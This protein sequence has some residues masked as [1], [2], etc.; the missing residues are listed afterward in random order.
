MMT[1]TGLGFRGHQSEADI[2]FRRIRS[3]D[4]IRRLYMW[5]TPGGGKTVIAFLAAKHLLPSIAD[6][7]CWVVPRHSLQKQAERDFIDAEKRALVGHSGS[8]RISTNDT[9]P[10]RGL[11]G[12]VTTYQALQYSGGLYEQEFQRK[13]YVLILDEPHHLEEDGAW[14]RAV[15]PLVNRA[16]FVILMSGTWERHDGKRVALAHYVAMDGGYRLAFPP[17]NDE[18]NDCAFITYSRSDALRQR[19]IKPLRFVRED[20]VLR[21]MRGNGERIEIPSLAELE[22]DVS[23]SLVVA[24][25][26]DY[27]FHLLDR[28][29]AD[30]RAHRAHKP[31]AKLLVVAA[32]IAHAQRY[33]RRLRDQ[34]VNRAMIATSDESEQATRAIEQFGKPVSDSAAVDALVT[35]AMAYEG[36]DVPAITHIACLTHIRSRPWIEQM[37][38]RA[39]RVD[40]GAGPYEEQWGY[41]YGPDDAL[42][43]DCMQK[44]LKE[45]EPFLREREERQ[46]PES[47]HTVQPDPENE[48]LPVDGALSRERILDLGGGEFIDYRTADRLRS[49]FTKHGVQGVIDPIVFMNL[50]REYQEEAPEAPAVALAEIAPSAMERQLRIG[51]DKHIRRYEAANTIEHGSVNKEIVKIFNKRRAEMTEVELRRLWAWCLENLPLS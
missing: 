7:L 2:L 37:I 24:L 27:A 32:S 6:A 11:S 34:G 29:V 36:M 1:V 40:G 13:R 48:L 20:A 14:A 4:P 47:G 46:R 44:I 26:T 45:Q 35:V 28:C 43:A 30:W 8:I 31:R 22:N 42:L 33:L 15:Q 10:S 39:A 9:D 12:F 17:L 21:A 50:H 23:K 38:A 41:V 25:E 16:A 18:F 51:I 5:V 19:A 3:G 49:L